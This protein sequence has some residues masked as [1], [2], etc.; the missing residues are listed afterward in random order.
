MAAAD[1]LAG[2]DAVGHLALALLGAG[3]V[4]FYVEDVG[5]GLPGGDWV[6][7]SAGEALVGTAHLRRYEGGTVA[8]GV[9]SRPHLAVLRPVLLIASYQR[10]YLRDQLPS[11]FQ[12]QISLDISSV[13]HLSRLLPLWYLMHGRISR[14]HL[15]II[16]HRIDHRLAHNFNITVH[17]IART[18]IPH[19]LYGRME[20]IFTRP[21]LHW[22]LVGVDLDYSLHFVPI[23]WLLRRSGNGFSQLTFISGGLAVVEHVVKL[24]VLCLLNIALGNGSLTHFYFI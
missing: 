5:G 8:V 23:L 4:C 18:L 19:A 21:I 9:G 20:S 22:G 16:L 17:R 1:V 7:V 10:L 15:L 6:V 24:L 2:G 11:L 12:L 14:S 13:S 3:L